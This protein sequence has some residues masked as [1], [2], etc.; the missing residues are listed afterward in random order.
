MNSEG[1]N[2][3]LCGHEV[4]DFLYHALFASA[5]RTHVGL[6]HPSQDLFLQLDCSVRWVCDVLP[7]KISQSLYLFILLS[8]EEGPSFRIVGRQFF[9]SHVNLL[10]VL[11]F[12]LNHDVQLSCQLCDPIFHG[13]HG[14]LDFSL[15]LLIELLQVLFCVALMLEE[16][17]VRAN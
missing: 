14:R 13:L 2:L 4:V 7:A 12:S 9:D 16:I 6:F 1:W 15:T 8:F 3:E 5:Q 17:A 10:L 11:I